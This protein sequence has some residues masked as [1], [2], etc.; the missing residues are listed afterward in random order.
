LYVDRS[1]DVA[2]QHESAMRT[3][4]YADM[5]SLADRLVA[6]AALLR[7]TAR[8]HPIELA[9]GV[10]VIFVPIGTPNLKAAID[11]TIENAGAGFDAL[12]DGVVLYHNNSF[13]FGSICYEVQGTPINSKARKTAL[14]FDP[15]RVWKHSGAVASSEGQ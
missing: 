13:V 1:V 12:V 10:P 4:V 6:P 7:R 11:H 8:I 5:Q 15:N 2:I 14:L 9:P 3:R